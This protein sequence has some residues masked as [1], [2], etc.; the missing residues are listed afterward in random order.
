[1]IARLTVVRGTTTEYPLAERVR[2]GWQNGV[3][4]Y[5]D[6]EVTEVVEL[7]VVRTGGRVAQ[8]QASLDAITGVDEATNQITHVLEAQV[9]A[10]LALVEQ[11]RI[12]NLMTLI[13][14]ED[15]DDVNEILAGLGV[16]PV[17]VKDQIVAA[18]GWER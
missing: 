14:D 11:Q 18:M 17:S 13:G 1:M 3:T 12:A 16:D 7:H 6:D 8:A 10:T 2:G 5:P 9:H 15:P 4:F